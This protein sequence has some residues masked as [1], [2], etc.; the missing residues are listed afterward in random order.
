M[1]SS[2]GKL[3]GIDTRP[4]LFLLTDFVL[5]K[6]DGSE[7][8]VDKGSSI[9]T[10]LVSS[11]FRLASISSNNRDWF[12]SSKVHFSDFLP[13]TALFRRFTLMDQERRECTTVDT[14]S[15]FKLGYF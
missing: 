9:V 2:R 4:G 15:S 6:S 1:I 10:V 13:N 12:F 3:S 5:V 11:S 14:F 7:I 8:N